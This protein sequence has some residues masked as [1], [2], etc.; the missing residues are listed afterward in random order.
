MTRCPTR[1]HSFK[2]NKEE[3]YLKQGCLIID[4][5][6]ERTGKANYIE[7]CRI[8]HD[9]TGFEA[10]YDK[11]RRR[12][13]QQSRPPGEAHE[14]QQLLTD[15]QEDALVEWLEHLCGTAHPVEKRGILDKAES[16]CGKKPS[17]G[18]VTLFLRRHPEIK[19]GRPS[20]LDPQRAWAFNKNVVQHHFQL[21]AEIVEEHEI[22]IEN[23]YN[24]DEKGCQLGG[25]RKARQQKYFISRTKRPQYRKHSSNLELITILE[26]VCADGSSELFPGFVFS[27]K[28]FSPE[29]FEVDPKIW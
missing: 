11:L 21:L 28:E 6:I 12:Y 7:A 17:M 23:I 22:P 9:Q 13:L 8:L 2:K 1:S 29:W 4:D 18:W 3:E 26:C 16:L 25:G 20:G 24:M 15:K 27:G 5:Q 14:S 10:S 19:L